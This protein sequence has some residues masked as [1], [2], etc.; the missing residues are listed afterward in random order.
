MLVSVY[1]ILVIHP[2]LVFILDGGF[3]KWKLEN[4]KITNKKK[5]LNHQNILLK[6]ILI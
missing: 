4:R 3:K 5:K 2:N 1:C 6:K